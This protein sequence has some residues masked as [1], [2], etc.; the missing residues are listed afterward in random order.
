MDMTM[1][2]PVA[3]EREIERAAVCGA[4]RAHGAFE[5]EEGCGRGDADGGR[6][7]ADGA[8]GSRNLSIGQ[9]GERAAARFLERRGYDIVDRNWACPAGEIDLV[10]RDGDT[11]VFVEVKT[12]TSL[13]AGL[14]EEAVDEQKR[15][16]YEILA[17][18]YLKAHDVE[19]APVRF[20]VVALLV[21]ASD[22]ALV[23]HHFNAFGASEPC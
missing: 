6:G 14:P 8:W 1:E 19:E 15:H 9:R 17:A 22:R 7:D 12:R 5:R 10:A 11:I 2:R 21:V 18:H 3:S 23:R 4:D 20:D 13:D 16:R